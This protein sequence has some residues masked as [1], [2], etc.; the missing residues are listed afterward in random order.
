[1]LFNCASGLKYPMPEAGTP[2]K[3]GRAIDW[4]TLTGGAPMSGRPS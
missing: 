4:R 2:L 1:V 3:L